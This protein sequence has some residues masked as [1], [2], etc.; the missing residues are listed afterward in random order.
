MP[1]LALQQ[2]PDVQQGNADAAEAFQRT[3]VAYQVLSD[4]GAREYYDMSRRVTAPWFV[5]TAAKTMAYR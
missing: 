4:P 3:V 5:R 2:H 1:Q